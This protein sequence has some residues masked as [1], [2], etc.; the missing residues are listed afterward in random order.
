MT[1]PESRQQVAMPISRAKLEALRKI[2]I[3]IEGFPFC[4]LESDAYYYHLNDY[5]HLLIQLQ[6]LAAP[7]LSET[8]ANRLNSLDYREYPTETRAEVEVL[9]FDIKE[10]IDTQEIKNQ[11]HVITLS[12]ELKQREDLYSVHT[13]LER[14]LNQ[15][16]LDPASAVTAASSMIESMC[17]VYLEERRIQLPTKQTIKPLWEKVSNSLGLDPSSKEDNDIK[18]V[19]SGLIAV[20]SGVGALRTHTGS[21]HGRGKMIYRLQ[22]RHAWLVINASSTIVTFLLAT[23]NEKTSESQTCLNGQQTG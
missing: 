3:D 18:Q 17:K 2:I 19:L 9:L 5:Q 6:R 11:N 10:A 16:D 7:L 13:D 22:P 20:V 23:D 4:S 12:H 8:N 14:A 1:F 15:A 21:A